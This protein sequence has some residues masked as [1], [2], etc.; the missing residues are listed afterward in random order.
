M[1]KQKIKDRE[2]N[3]VLV[4]VIVESG[5]C[6]NQGEYQIDITNFIGFLDISSIGGVDD[7]SLI[8]DCIDEHVSSMKIDGDAVICLMLK[9]SGEWEDVFWHKYYEVEREVIYN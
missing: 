9:E 8:R 3:Y 1:N 5:C 2:I 4:N 6:I 7:I